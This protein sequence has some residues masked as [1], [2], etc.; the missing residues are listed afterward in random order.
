MVVIA[1]AANVVVEA[2]LMTTLARARKRAAQEIVM[3]WPACIRVKS[4][5]RLIL[6]VI[7][8]GAIARMESARTTALARTTLT[9]P[10]HIH[11]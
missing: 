10:T 9:V 3:T 11:A 7:A 8:A 4:W 1:A 6:A 5:S 2:V